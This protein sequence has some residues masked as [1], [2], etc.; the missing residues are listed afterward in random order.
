MNPHNEHK[1]DVLNRLH[2]NRSTGLSQQE[3][4]ARLSE[5]GENALAQAKQTP[6]WKQFLL[7][8][9]EHWS[10]SCSLLS[11]SHGPAPATIFSCATTRLTA[12][13]P[14]TKASRSSY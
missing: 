2:T 7:S 1:A 14:C 8:L 11:D 4:A 9:K 12:W 13:P 10:S 5:Y 6:A 3:A